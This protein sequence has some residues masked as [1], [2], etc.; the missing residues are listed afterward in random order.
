MKP[1]ICLTIVLLASSALYA[2]HPF[3]ASEA[4]RSL[5]T[6]QDIPLDQLTHEEPPVQQHEATAETSTNQNETKEPTLLETKTSFYHDNAEIDGMLSQMFI[7]NR[8]SPQELQAALHQNAHTLQ[9]LIIPHIQKALDQLPSHPFVTTYKQQLNTVIHDITRMKEQQRNGITVESQY[10]NNMVLFVQATYDF[11]KQADAANIS[12]S[13]LSPKLVDHMEILYIT[14]QDCSRILDAQITPE[15]IEQKSKELAAHFEPFIQDIKEMNQIM[16]NSILFKEMLHDGY[17]EKIKTIWKNFI[18]EAQNERNGLAISTEF[19]KTTLYIK[20]VTFMFILRLIAYLIPPII[21][22]IHASINTIHNKS[23]HAGLQTFDKLHALADK[24]KS[25]D[26][27]TL[28]QFNAAHENPAFGDQTAFEKEEVKYAELFHDNPAITKSLQTMTI[29][30]PKTPEV[31]QQLENYMAAVADEIIPQIQTILTQS[32]PTD[33]TSLLTTQLTTIT[34]DINRLHTA[35]QEHNIV[36]PAQYANNIVAL[37]QAVHLFADRVGS[38]VPDDVAHQ[39]LL[40]YNSV[41]E[42]S[43]LISNDKLFMT[44]QKWAEISLHLQKTLVQADELSQQINAQPMMNKIFGNNGMITKL[45]AIWQDAHTS[46][47]DPF[48]NDFTNKKTVLIAGAA[49]IGVILAYILRWTLLAIPYI[50]GVTSAV[51]LQSTHSTQ[52]YISSGDIQNLAQK[53]IRHIHPNAVPLEQNVRVQSMMH[54]T[55]DTTSSPFDDGVYL[56][57]RTSPYAQS[58]ELLGKNQSVK[59]WGSLW[60]SFEQPFTDNL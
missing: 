5:H 37:V 40:S 32:Q 54:H 19:L 29:E 11:A 21:A 16:D 34:K 57:N 33:A 12:F 22:L 28:T 42:M 4:L 31:I 48:N 7:S 60:D 1:I 47:H 23:L 43:R 41:E 2:A 17:T 52:R 56:E 3:H 51:L 55:S 25:T 38:G 10:Q 8:L 15:K 59:E 50:I 26:N 14:T 35:Y 45:N 9:T 53:S 24:N 30:N 58:K 39:L 36:Q 20:A 6:P 18:I 13:S 27:P 44:Q 46:L 49:T